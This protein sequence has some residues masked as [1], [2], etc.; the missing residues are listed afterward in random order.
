VRTDDRSGPG[1]RRIRVPGRT[2]ARRQAPRLRRRGHGGHLL[3]LARDEDA[4]FLR[5]TIAANK[6]WGW[7]ALGMS[8]GS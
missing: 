1:H 8:G 6:V 5:A 2:S 7:V 3:A 4:G